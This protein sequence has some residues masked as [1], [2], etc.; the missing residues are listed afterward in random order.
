MFGCNFMRCSIRRVVH[1][2]HLPAVDMGMLP[3]DVGHDLIPE[4]EES[5]LVGFFIFMDMN[6]RD[7]KGIIT[8]SVNFFVTCSF[9]EFLDVNHQHVEME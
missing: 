8:V 9:V 1:H 7:F 4:R 3:V 2:R 6:R 5:I